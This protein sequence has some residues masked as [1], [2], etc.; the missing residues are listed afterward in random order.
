VT[1]PAGRR[2]RLTADGIASSALRLVDE[3][4]LEALSMRR[5]ADDLGVGTM[6]L[7]GYFR[8]K[9]ELLDA[10]VDAAT[11]DFEPPARRGNPRTRLVAYARAAR[12]WLLRHPALV[13][14]RGREPI[15]RPAALRI[16]EL[17][18]EALLDAGLE[19][20][21]AARAFRVLFVYTFGAVAF[22]AAEPGEDERR[23]VTAAM[24]ALPAAEFPA[25]GRAAEGAGAALGGAEQFDYGVGRL[26]DGFGIR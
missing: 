10:V 1:A 13:Q 24:R 3:E 11:Q 14:L 22:S 18:I 9:D 15:L 5:L 25:L 17:G 19:P 23:A 16:T 12:E 7:Y 8:N 20:A 26:L 21:E 4:G 2:A 6:T